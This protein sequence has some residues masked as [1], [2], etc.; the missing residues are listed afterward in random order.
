[1]KTRTTIK[2]Q[3]PVTGQ[4]GTAGILER[5]IRTVAVLLLSIL[6]ATACSEGEPV[7]P[8]E[9]PPALGAAT[10]GS[11][12][13]G[14]EGGSGTDYR[15][16]HRLLEQT[17]FGPTSQ[18]M[19]AVT[20]AGIE[21]WLNAQFDKTPTLLLPQLQNVGDARW[22]EY[23]NLWWRNAITAEDQLRQRVAYA[24]SQ[25]FVVSAQ[26]GLDDEQEGLANYYDI[27]VRHAFG[28]YRDLLTDITLSP[29]MGE[30]LSMKGNQKPEPDANIRPD[31]NYAREL[32]QLFS[33]GLVKLNNDGSVITDDAG[34]PVPTYDQDT[35]EAF[36]HV[37]T[38]WHFS[39]ADHFVWPSDSDYLTPMVAWEDYHDTQPKVLLDGVR[40]EGGKSAEEDL[41]IALDVIFNHP[42]VGP[43]I[44][45]K[46]IQNLVTS[47]PSPG[48][49]DDVA[50]VFNANEDGVRG[51]MG[52][53]IKAIIMHDEARFGH[54]TYPTT[55]GKLKEPALRVT[56]LWR[57]FTPQSISPEF[58]Y[59][60]SMNDIGQA[61]LNSPSVFNFFTPGFSQPGE[62]RNRN[63]VSPEFEIHDESSIIGITNRLLS[64]SVWSHNFNYWSD[65]HRIAL[66]I[67]REVSLEA[68]D[69]EKMLDHLDLLLL[70]GDMSEP[71]RNITRELMDE[72]TFEG[73]GPQRVIEAIFLIVSS[74]EAAIQI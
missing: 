10:G 67:R 41:H 49:I 9:P 12:D 4:P 59:G 42:N 36:A 64:N 68:E 55:F 8:S 17:T 5:R 74:P 38:G 66:D 62:I 16:S 34:M 22:S 28:N 18:D 15:A 13:G 39:N 20:A 70:G 29:I 40:V 27:L 61:P 46:L 71:L 19:E 43:F 25:I 37:F 54:E 21:P 60:W 26:S 57:A 44:A 33:I 24:L 31:E 48:Y 45:K 72:Y 7:P 32:L 56:S 58:N 23:V 73:G 11:I 53:M 65:Q 35:V 51:S 30:Y 63:L 69:P 6:F 3:H 52:S 2:S 1:M 50:S 14:T 47:N